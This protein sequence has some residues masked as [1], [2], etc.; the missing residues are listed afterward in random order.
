M[1]NSIVGLI[2]LAGFYAHADISSIKSHEELLLGG[3]AVFDIAIRVVDFVN[4]G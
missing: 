2:W 1:Y 4:L 3:V